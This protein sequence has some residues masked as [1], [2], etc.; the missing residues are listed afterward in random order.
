MKFRF[1][2]MQDVSAAVTLAAL[3]LCGYPIA[4]AENATGGHQGMHGGMQHRSMH[5]GGMQGGMHGAGKHQAGAGMHGKKGGAGH[6]GRH[7]L[8]G[9]DWRKTLTE[10][11]KVQLDQLHLEFAKNKHVLKAGI[12]SLKVQLAV[13][14]ISDDAQTEVIEAQINNLLMAKRQLIQA[15]YNYISAQR[16]V[17]TPD[18]RVSFD[19]EVLHKAGGHSK[20]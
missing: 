10:E 16:R 3:L 14:A 11:Q 8:F 20:H 17:L 13:L 9:D 6:H 1:T 12:K 15:K 2:R 7:H 5:R 19:M 4:Q 18:Q